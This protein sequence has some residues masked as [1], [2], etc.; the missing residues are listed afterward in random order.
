[1]PEIVISEESERDQQR[2]VLQVRV[3]HVQIRGKQG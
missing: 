1:M 3:Q 2:Q